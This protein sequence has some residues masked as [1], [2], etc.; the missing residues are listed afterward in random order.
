[1]DMDNS[2]EKKKHEMTIIKDNLFM[3]R[4]MDLE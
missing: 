1:M 2:K 4:K 3:I